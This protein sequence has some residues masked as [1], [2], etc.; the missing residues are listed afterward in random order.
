MLA[1]KE[2]HRRRLQ[3]FTRWFIWERPPLSPG[4]SEGLSK[5]VLSSARLVGGAA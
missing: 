3:V 4:E 1:A 2:I 5:G